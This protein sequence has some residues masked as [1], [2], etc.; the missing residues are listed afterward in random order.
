MMGIG[1][2][3]IPFGFYLSAL[4]VSNNNVLRSMMRKTTLSQFSNMI[5]TTAEERQKVLS[6][7]VV[8]KAKRQ[9]ETIEDITIETCQ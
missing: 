2:Y 8:K 3:L 6:N 9:Q 5:G 4:S 1:S 7:L